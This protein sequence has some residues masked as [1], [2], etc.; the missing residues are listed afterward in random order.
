MTFVSDLSHHWTATANVGPGEIVYVC[1]SHTGTTF[2]HTGYIKAATPTLEVRKLNY[3]LEKAEGGSAVDVKAHGLQARQHVSALFSHTHMLPIQP[4]APS[5]WCCVRLSQRH[6]NLL[7][8]NAHKTSNAE[9][10][11]AH[12]VPLYSW[13]VCGR[14]I[15]LFSTF[16]RYIAGIH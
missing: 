14:K 6:L 10:C 2:T 4:T 12:S 13:G 1:V 9:V 16:S 8:T 3:N 11:G 15:M 7:K 5:P